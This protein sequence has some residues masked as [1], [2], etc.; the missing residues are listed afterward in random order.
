MVAFADANAKPPKPEEVLI[1]TLLKAFP[2]WRVADDRLTVKLAVPAEPVWTNG[3]WNEDEKRVRWTQSLVQAKSDMS[4]FP[5]VCYAVWSEPN[6]KS[7]TERFGKVI[8]K[9]ETLA[10]YCLWHQGLTEAEAKEWDSFLLSLKPGTDL[11][12]RLRT[13]RFSVPPGTQQDRNRLAKEP[14]EWLL[15]GLGETVE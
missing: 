2:L 3:Q 9:G 8:L 4:E 15:E 5:A 14:R 10:R 13:F 11:A 12:S 6:A 7:Q 1:A